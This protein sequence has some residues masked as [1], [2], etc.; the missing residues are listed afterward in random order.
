MTLSLSDN[1]GATLSVELTEEP[2]VRYTTISCVYS[3]RSLRD[4]DYQWSMTVS[5]VLD[6]FGPY[7]AAPY[8]S[9]LA[10]HR[11]ALSISDSP[12]STLV[13]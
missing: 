5:S 3:I 12:K 8:W 4:T 10:L 9:S 7:T 11:L 1:K 6:C 2:T 13:F